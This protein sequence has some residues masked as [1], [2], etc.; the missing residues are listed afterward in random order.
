MSDLLT[1]FPTFPLTPPVSNLLNFI[2]DARLTTADLV[3]LDPMS[4]SRRLP[5][6]LNTSL[7]ELKSLQRTLVEHIHADI[8][9]LSSLPPPRTITTHSPTLDRLLNKIPTQAITEFA[10]E[11]GSGKTQILLLL[12][13]TV[14]L[15]PS[16]GGLGRPAVYISTEA[17]L[18]TLRLIQMK[19]YISRDLPVG[20]QPTTDKVFSIVCSDLETQEHIIRYQLPV[21]VQKFNVGLVVIDSIAANFRA[22][23]ERP[24]NRN[25]KLR[26][27][28]TSTPSSS[29]SSSST[30]APSAGARHGSQMAQRGKEMVRLAATLRH[31]AINHNLAV[32][33]SNQVSDKF[34]PSASSR[35]PLSSSSSARDRDDDDDDIMS[36]DFQL[37]WFAGCDEGLEGGGKIPALGL[38]WA[39]LLATRVVI[40]KSEDPKTGESRRSL[41]VAYSNRALAGEE[42]GIEVFEGGVKSVNDGGDECS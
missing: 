36:L 4:I 7:L 13:L 5:S 9:R 28:N 24:M 34:T 42:V 3:A 41:R 33:V 6:Q 35:T 32:V 21:L 38:V 15:S 40:R 1:L 22:E 23:F 17:P 16:R 10:G 19:N 2:G 37:K 18:S 30:G 8:A 14:Q 25:K 29:P 39:N 31:L 11:S 12:T 20:E 27:S 26:S